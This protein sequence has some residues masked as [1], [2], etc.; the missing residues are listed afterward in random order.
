MAADFTFVAGKYWR[1]LVILMI[2]SGMM[3]MVVT[4]N[5]E[6]DIK[7][8]ASVLNEIGVGGARANLNG[9][10]LDEKPSLRDDGQYCDRDIKD[11]SPHLLLSG[12]PARRIQSD[13]DPK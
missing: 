12:R 5:R 13:S 8:I 6:N 3:G 7:S 2:H 11:S 4:G 10:E 9:G 1:I